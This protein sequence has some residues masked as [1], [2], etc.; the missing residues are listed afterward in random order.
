MLRPLAQTIASALSAWALP[1]GQT[2]EFD[3][4]RYVQPPLAARATTYATLFNIYDQ[5]TGERAITIP[6]IRAR[7]RWTPGDADTKLELTGV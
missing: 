6:E 5:A 1:L 7:E 4:D 2:L 3:P